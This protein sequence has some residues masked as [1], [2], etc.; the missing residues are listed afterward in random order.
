MEQ[1][2][3]SEHLHLCRSVDVS[4]VLQQ[5]L[6]RRLVAVLGSQDGAGPSVLAGGMMVAS[7]KSGFGR[8]ISNG[9]KHWK[10]ICLAL[11]L[12]TNSASVL[13]DCVRDLA[14]AQTGS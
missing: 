4:L 11:P 3:Q 8:E 5:K 2:Q 6:H 13:Y 1:G 10:S 7:V 12:G 9:A 14:T